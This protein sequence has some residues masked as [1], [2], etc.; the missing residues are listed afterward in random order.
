MRF[1]FCLIGN[2]VLN[3]DFFC[4]VTDTGLLLQGMCHLLVWWCVIKFLCVQFM[5]PSIYMGSL[6]C[7]LIPYIV[8]SVTKYLK[9]LNYYL[10]VELI[11]HIDHIKSCSVCVCEGVS[12]VIGFVEVSMHLPIRKKYR[13]NLS[14][15][16]M[17]SWKNI[18]IIL[19][20]LGVLIYLRSW[21]H[22]H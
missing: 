1:C 18:F 19:S 5:W 21:F 15:R 10:L 7:L 6:I 17:N 3:Y 14:L 9:I 12:W 4:L 2:A 13:V 16:R 11:I 20:Y 22:C 8:L